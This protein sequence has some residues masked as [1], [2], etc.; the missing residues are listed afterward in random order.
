MELDAQQSVVLFYGFWQMVVCLFAFISLFGIWY[1]IGRKQNDVGQVWLAL[2][3]LC[4]SVSGALDVVFVLNLNEIGDYAVYS[5]GSRSILSLMNSL[6]I[7]LALPWFR[8][9]PSLLQ[10]VIKSKYW[11]LIVGLPF[12]FSLLP[13]LSKIIT[14][15]QEALI[16]ELDVYYSILTLIVLGWV[17]W[18]S[19][20][21]R[22]LSIL[23]ILSVSCIVFIF[24]AQIFKLSDNALYQLMFSAIFKTNLIMIFFALALSWVKDL[25]DKII[26]NPLQ[27]KL[28][29][30]IKKLANGKFTHLVSFNG[31]FEEN[32]E[33]AISPS[34]YQL[35]KKFVDKRKSNQGGWLEIKPKN[36]QKIQD[37]E[38]KDYNEIKRLIHAILDGYFGKSSWTK[39]QHEMPLKSILLEKSTEKERMIRL[40]LPPENL[41]IK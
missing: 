7:L 24:A 5:S 38:I 2:S 36:A 28:S 19:F 32:K 9:I 3:V 26:A 15:N 25:T 1:H 30:S 22:R 31:L 41:T 11:I 29:M 23:A 21:K 34:H 40:S 20:I 8:Y 6:F 27:V 4:W 12:V 35:L 17:L 18:E 13:T 10:P 39:E 14:K 33:I 16:N 37:Y